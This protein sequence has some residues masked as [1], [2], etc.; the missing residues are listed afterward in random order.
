MDENR[1]EV[2]SLERGEEK[3]DLVDENEEPKPNAFR[4]LM[5]CKARTFPDWT[6]PD[7]WL[8]CAAAGPLAMLNAASPTASAL[9]HFSAVLL[10][11]A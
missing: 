5:S 1:E 11:L 8:S 6:T 7:H 3:K 4:L 9:P 2:G 10:W